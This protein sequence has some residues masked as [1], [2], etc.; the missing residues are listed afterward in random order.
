[1][2]PRH[3]NCPYQAEIRLS[4]VHKRPKI[5]YYVTAGIFSLGVLYFFS[6]RLVEITESSLT[7]PFNFT[8]LVVG[9]LAVGSL[10]ITPPKTMT[11][12]IHR[13][14]LIIMVSTSCNC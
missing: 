14:G 12:T 8:F 10:F 9:N 1:M 4:D 2:Q 3:Q 5:S 7:S 6:A 13:I 11:L